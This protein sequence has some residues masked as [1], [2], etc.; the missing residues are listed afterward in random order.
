MNP[1]DL[2]ILDDHLDMLPACHSLECILALAKRE[3]DRDELFEIHDTALEH[4]DGAGETGR[5]VPRDAAH[6][7]FFVGHGEHGDGS[8]C[9]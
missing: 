8:V 7:E 2:L 5:G 3:S 6:V 9:Q 4:V 1:S